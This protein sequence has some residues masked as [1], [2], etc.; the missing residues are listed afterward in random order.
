MT[1]TLRVLSRILLATT[2]LLALC[3]PVELAGADTAHAAG[4]LAVGNCG[5]YGVAY[6]FTEVE[7]ASAAALHQCAGDCKVAASMRGNCAALS[8]DM[9][10]ACGAFGYAAAPQ[11]GEAENA[12]LR[13]CYRNG[14]KDCIIRAF[15][16][17]AKG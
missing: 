17:D 14:G 6:D 8:I 12:A 1:G 13:Y 9:R 10:N 7:Q 4:A 2:L 11:L 15:V 3:V 5:A 16:C